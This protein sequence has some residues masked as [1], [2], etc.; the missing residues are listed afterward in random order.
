[1]G[2]AAPPAAPPPGVGGGMD[3]LLGL[4]GGSPAAAPGAFTAWN[5]N[6][7]VIDFVCTKEPGNP[8]ITNI[9]ASFS[10][11]TGAQFEGMNFQVAVPKYMQLKMTPPSSPIVPPNNSGK[12]TQLFKVANQMHGQKPLLLRV[13]IEYSTMGQAIS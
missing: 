4:L 9:E 12:T 3:D 7:L 11:G 8:S 1:M 13:K 10:N 5:K 6:G 2:A